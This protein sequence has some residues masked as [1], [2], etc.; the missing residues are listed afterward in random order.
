MN[1]T[2]ISAYLI[3]VI[4]LAVCLALA[5]ISANA[6][7][8]EAG[9]NP[10]DKKKRQMWFW[11]LAVLTPVATIAVAYFAAYQGIKVPSRQ[12]A[13]LTAMGIS[14]GVGF[15]AYVVVGFV[16]SKMFSHGKLGSWF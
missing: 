1:A 14:A 9:I 10:Q 7:R 12:T 5:I 4:V 15:V 11:A 2:T 3:G 16:L 6:I 13:Y 8:Y